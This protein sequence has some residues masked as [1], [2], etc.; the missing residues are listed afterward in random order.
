MLGLDGLRREVQAIPL[1]VVAIGGI[2]LE[3]V[4]AVARTGVHGV[5]VVSDLWSGGNPAR[6][7]EALQRGFFLC[8]PERVRNG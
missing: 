2:S 1:P 5:A 6:Q 7:V 4:G 8:A 3:V